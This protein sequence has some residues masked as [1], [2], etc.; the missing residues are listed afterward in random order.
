M[1]TWLLLVIA[2]LVV[3]FLAFAFAIYNMFC[4]GLSFE[5]GKLFTGHLGAM[6]FMA[7]GGLMMAIG[8]VMLVAQ[9]VAKYLH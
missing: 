2:G 4:N 3:G 7:L 9:L 8:V 5:I 6:I 1:E